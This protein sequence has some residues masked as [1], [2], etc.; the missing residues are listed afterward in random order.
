MRICVAVILALFCFATLTLFGN[1]NAQNNGVQLSPAKQTINLGAGKS[2][3]VTLDVKNIASEST[4]YDVLFDNFTS[5]GESGTPKIVMD[6]LPNGLKNWLSGGKNITINANSTYT[7]KATVNVPSGTKDGT[8]YGL[9]RLGSATNKLVSSAASILFVNV[10]TITEKISIESF[11]VVDEFQIEGSF[12]ATDIVAEIKATGN[13]YTIPKLSVVIIDKGGEQI[14]TIDLNPEKVGVLPN[15]TRKFSVKQTPKFVPGKTYT[16]VLTAQA[17]TDK[18]IEKSI[19]INNTAPVVPAQTETTEQAKD[20]KPGNSLY[21]FIVGGLILLLVI[22]VTTL[23]ILK[24]HKKTPINP[25]S[26]NTSEALNYNS[27]TLPDQNNEPTAQSEDKENPDIPKI[28]SG[29]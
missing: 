23:L 10:G 18:A 14:E 22:V 3:I 12:I 28:N 17:G 9:I 13:G 4:S 1:T 27:P 8:Y 7:Y 5:D 26:F 24:R 2:K 16:A 29:A 20:K 21:V 15:T 11:E 19:A 6:D 25:P